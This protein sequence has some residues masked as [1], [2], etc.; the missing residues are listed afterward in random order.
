MNS[1]QR[2]AAGLFRQ[3]R[4]RSAAALVPALGLAGLAL[5]AVAP[6]ETSPTGAPSG[7]APVPFPE[8]LSQTGLYLS[9]STTI[10]PG[11][12]EYSPQYPLWSDGASK[13]RWVHLPEG[14]HIDGSDPDHFRF[15]AGTRFFKEFSFGE[16]VETRV[17][18]LTDGGVRYA[19]YVWNS[20]GSDAFLAPDNGLRGVRTLDGGLRYDAPSQ[21]DCGACHGGRGAR[22]VLGFDALQLSSDR[23][24]LAAHQEPLAEGAVD[25]S[26]LVRRDLIRNLPW[27]LIE[28]PPALQA[29]TALER[30]ARGYMYGNCA[31][32]HNAQGALALLGLDLDEAVGIEAQARPRSPL[33]GAASRF[34]LPGMQHSLRVAP[35]APDESVL[36][37]RMGSLAPVLRMP[38]LGTRRVDA[39]GLRLIKDWITEAAPSSSL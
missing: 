25:L 3:S 34:V 14:Q 4:A 31:H 19:T 9:G 5:V 8:K 18:E 11:H 13:R 12:L 24:P 2:R 39:E 32:C 38:P 35:G 23:D 26:E 33:I 10:A 21:S 17:L 6:T 20:D 36:A 29:D 30:A 16:R 22:A 37:A 27:Q 1:M 15:P 28:T 7:N